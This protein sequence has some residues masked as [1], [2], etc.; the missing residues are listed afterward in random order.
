MLLANQ[1]FDSY[2]DIDKFDGMTIVL[3]RRLDLG[4]INTNSNYGVQFRI[5][6]WEE[7]LSIE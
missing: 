5:E 7:W 2:E 4:I 1:V 3:T 6:D